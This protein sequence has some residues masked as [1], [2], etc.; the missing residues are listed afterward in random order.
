VLLGGCRIESKLGFSI[1][2]GPEGGVTEV[3]GGSGVVPGATFSLSGLPGDMSYIVVRVVK[4]TP[5]SI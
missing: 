4:Y 5:L 2:S 3:D 1:W